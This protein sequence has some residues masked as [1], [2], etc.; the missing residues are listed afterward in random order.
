MVKI[1]GQRSTFAEKES[2][3]RGHILNRTQKYPIAEKFKE[4]SKT[5]SNWGEVRTTKMLSRLRNLVCKVPTFIFT[6]RSQQAQILKNALYP[7]TSAM[8]GTHK[9]KCNTVYC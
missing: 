7:P 1:H 8:Q 6:F 2:L 9:S 4:T 5:W 3:I